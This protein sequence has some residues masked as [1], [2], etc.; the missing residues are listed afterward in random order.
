MQNMVTTLVTAL[1]GALIAVAAVVVLTNA[2]YMPLNEIQLRGY[3]LAHP[4]LVAEMSD[5]AQQAEDTRSAAAQ[6]TA[7][8]KV[9]LN[10]FFDPRLAYITGPVNAPNTMVE[11]Y[12]Y[13]CP[14]CRA[15][16]PAVKK[17]YEQHK[18]DTRF[19]FIEYPIE[20]LHGPG[21]VLAARASLAA[22]AQ[23]DRF[24]AFHY[25]MMG[26]TEQMTEDMVVADA[27]KA[28]LDV[29]KLKADMANPQIDKILADA[30]DFG[31]KVQLVGTPTFIINGQAHP[32]QMDDASFAAAFQQKAS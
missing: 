1:C 19:A 22:R 27:Q 14:Y 7:I 23:P 6:A 2:G 13:D 10:A 4:Q 21:A 16:L 3:L 24:L 32:Q 17:I 20:S 25:L 12:D 18:N 26:E 29:K 28:G 5:A 9:G 11:F 15:S 31:K 8:R 30:H